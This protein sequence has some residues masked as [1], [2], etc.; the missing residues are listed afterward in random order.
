MDKYVKLIQ[1]YSKETYK[2]LKRKPE[3]WLRYPFIVPGSES[4][5]DCLWDW[6]SWLTNIAI[7]QI[8]MDENDKNPEFAEYEKG[9][10]LN[11]LSHTTEEG[12][13]PIS[14]TPSSTL[15]KEAGDKITNIHK[16]C[17]AQHA[18]FVIGVNDGKVDWLKPH[19]HKLR[20]YI[21]YY[22]KNMFHEKTGLYFWQ[23]DAAIGV[24]NDP[25]TFYRPDRSSASIYLNC[26][27]YKE[28]LAMASIC[29][30]LELDSKEYVSAAETLKQSIQTHLWDERNG[31]YYSADLNLKEIDPNEWLHS[32]YPRHWH[33]L[34]QRIDCWSGFLA[35]WAGVAT[36]EQAERMVRENMQKE[37]LFNGKYGI[38]SLAKTEKMYCVVKSG[39]PSCW[40]GPVWGIANYFC[41][42]GL[43]NYG[44]VKEAK[45]LAM[46]TIRLF[47]QDI[48]LCGEFHEYYDAD[49]GVGINTQGFQSWNLLVNNMIAE[50]YEQSTVKEF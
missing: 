48:E 34:I 37:E 41:Y 12:W 31:F 9:C 42:R 45:E 11:F 17:L 22:K 2:L 27:M 18:A 38:R 3:G 25:S 5:S 33:C 14:I 19:V 10:I 23:D 49:T 47:G 15:P 28:L 30:Q 1:C 50:V 36:E 32:G 8:M 20:N 39:N 24:D 7:R 35:M 4:Y 13:M 6:D 46:K 29:E 21:N 44:Y 26:M 40:L 16:P 43:M